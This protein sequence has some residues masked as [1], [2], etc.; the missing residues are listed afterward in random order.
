LTHLAT[1]FATRSS[2]SCSLA[3]TAPLKLP[4]NGSGHWEVIQSH[5][6]YEGVY[7][8]LRDAVLKGGEQ[9]QLL[10]IGAAGT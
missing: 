3:G 7:P 6:A 8:I 10:P 4:G 1:R 9:L 2:L 5:A